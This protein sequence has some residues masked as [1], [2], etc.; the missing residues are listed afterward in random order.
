M[1]ENSFEK[2]HDPVRRRCKTILVVYYQFCNLT[3]VEHIN[4]EAY[5]KEVLKSSS[6]KLSTYDDHI[7]FLMK[8]RFV[9]FISEDQKC[10]RWDLEDFDEVNISRFFFCMFCMSGLNNDSILRIEESIED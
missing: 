1:N 7:P 3:I 9:G 8:I 10:R 4:L 6:L 5:R 2:N